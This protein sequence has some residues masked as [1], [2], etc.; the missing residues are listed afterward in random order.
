MAN[1][2]QARRGRKPVE[3]KDAP[4]GMDDQG[5]PNAPY[6]YL[7][8]GKPRVFP[9]A[10]AEVDA[11]SLDMLAAPEEVPAELVSKSAPARARDEKQQTMDRLVADL[12]KAWT[13]AGSPAAWDKMPKKSYAVPASTV[14]GLKK[15]IN[16][17]ADYHGIAVRFGTPVPTVR[18]VRNPRFG[19]E[20]QPPT[21]NA[22]LVL[23]SFAAKD[24]RERKSPAKDG[25]QK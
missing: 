8:N 21:V 15:L 17:A 20:N 22:Q 10:T 24:K 4:H 16:R 13:D 2:T 14:D 1:E 19:Q 11:L 5:K 12:H 6:G 7:A 3:N 18:Q 9:Q 23:I 25:D